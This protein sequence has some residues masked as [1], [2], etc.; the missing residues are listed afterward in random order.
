MKEN[1]AHVFKKIEQWYA[2]KVL[3]ESY[4][5]VKTYILVPRKIVG[6]LIFHIKQETQRALFCGAWMPIS[7]AWTE[8][9]KDFSSNNF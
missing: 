2:Y 9:K 1:R 6:L 8:R 7:Y 3:L 4:S 5:L